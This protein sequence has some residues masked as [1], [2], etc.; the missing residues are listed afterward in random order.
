VGH[1]LDDDDVTLFPPND[2]FIREP[3]SS[4]PPIEH[5]K[6]FRRAVMAGAGRA[7]V[8]SP[9]RG[10][11]D[12]VERGAVEILVDQ[13]RTFAVERPRFRPQRRE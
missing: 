2:Y 6:T 13:K 9:S 11:Q 4:A 12:T 3:L 7:T 5:G 1:W 10:E 8:R